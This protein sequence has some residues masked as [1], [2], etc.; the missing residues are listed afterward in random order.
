MFGRVLVMAQILDSADVTDDTHIQNHVKSHNF[1]LRL[2]EFHLNV[3]SSRP[4]RSPLLPRT[5]AAAAVTVLK[6]RVS[7]KQLCPF[8]CV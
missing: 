6:N 1:C 4:D 8:V 7:G 2:Q 5:A 3:V